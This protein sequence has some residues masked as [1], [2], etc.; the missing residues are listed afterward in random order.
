MKYTKQLTLATIALFMVTGVLGQLQ[1]PA[2]AQNCSGFFDEEINAVFLD[3]RDAEGRL[4]VRWEQFYYSDLTQQC[5]NMTYGALNNLTNGSLSFNISD[6]ENINVCDYFD[7]EVGYQFS[8][9]DHDIG[10]IIIEGR[11]L[12]N[13]TGPPYSVD[14]YTLPELCNVSTE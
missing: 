3:C 1:V 2:V 4:V 12:T 13:C 9:A 8:Q 11:V 10:L 5:V 14:N 6:D 7:I